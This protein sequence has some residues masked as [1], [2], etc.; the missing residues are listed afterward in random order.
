[1]AIFHKESELSLKEIK[2]HNPGKYE[3]V[4]AAGALKG[5]SRKLV[6]IGCY[7]PPNYNVSRGHKA[8]GFIAGCVTK[9]KRQYQDP[10]I[11]I[12]GDF[13]LW[14]V[15]E[16]LADHIDIQEAP[17]GPTR[18]GR[19]IDRIFSNFQNFVTEAG[20]VPPLESDDQ[21]AKKAIMK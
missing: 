18:S 14:L 13:N 2:L 9:A 21:T 3:V 1:M 11:I 8:M 19:A 20:T 7:L 15:E 10:F 6:V 5:Y 4:M 12:A 17:V 16:V